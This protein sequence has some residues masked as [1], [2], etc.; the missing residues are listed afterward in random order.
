ML[1]KNGLDNGVHFTVSKAVPI[2]NYATGPTH[3]LYSSSKFMYIINIAP[4]K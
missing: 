4:V 3:S 1:A 2:S